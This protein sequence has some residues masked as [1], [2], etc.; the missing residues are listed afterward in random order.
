MYYSPELLPSRKPST[1]SKMTEKDR[2][3]SRFALFFYSL[4]HFCGH[5]EQS[6]YYMSMVTTKSINYSYKLVLTHTRLSTESQCTFGQYSAGRKFLSGPWSICHQLKLGFQRWPMVRYPAPAAR[7]ILTSGPGT[8][9]KDRPDKF[10]IRPILGR[11]SIPTWEGSGF[12]KKL[13]FFF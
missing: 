6:R 13:I 3:F 12:Q 1:N 4:L 7:H 9:V 11:W 10:G 5:S 2:T 8:I